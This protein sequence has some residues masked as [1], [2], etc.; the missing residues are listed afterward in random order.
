[1]LRDYDK[2]EG[3]SLPHVF[4]ILE[5]FDE[6]GTSTIDDAVEFYR[7]VIEENKTAQVQ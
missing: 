4:S 7:N 5:P 1:M 6:I 2:F 3:K